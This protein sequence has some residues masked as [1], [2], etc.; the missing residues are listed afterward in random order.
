MTISTSSSPQPVA[1]AAD[2]LEAWLMRQPG[3][4]VLLQEV[5]QFY[6][7]YTVAGKTVKK[8]GIRRFAA[9]HA[10]RFQVSGEGHDMAICATGSHRA[11][12]EERRFDTDGQLYT[13]AEFVGEYG[14]TLQWEQAEREW[15]QA[16]AEREWEQTQAPQAPQAQEP[17]AHQHA[18]PSAAPSVLENDV[19]PNAM[20]STEDVSLISHTHV[21]P[22]LGGPHPP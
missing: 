19:H 22:W 10:K 11:G 6:E 4:M 16:G 17:A 12:D 2:A 3:Q 14:G 1:V 9:D 7:Q 5:C 8:R 21:S 15:E 20:L 18:E 13:K